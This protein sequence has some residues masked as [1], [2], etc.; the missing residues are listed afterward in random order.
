I[1][2]TRERVP[3]PGSAA[4][5]RVR[6]RPAAE[7][8]SEPYAAG[9][10]EPARL[11]PF[12]DGRRYH[13]T[14]LFH[15][16]SGFPTEDPAEVDALLRRLHAKVDLHR[17]ELPAV[18]ELELHDAEV[19]VFACGI[20]AR[21]ARAAVAQARAGGLR[22]GLLRPLTL[23][24]FPD[25]A[26]ARTA[27]QVNTIV[28]AEM[29]LGQLAREVARAAAGACRVDQLNRVDGAPIWPAQVLERL[30]AAVPA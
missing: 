5:A 29:N 12:G 26:V 30:R 15:D 25:E 17:D 14:G 11:V 21:A 27:R 4:L 2:H 19:A 1:G 10:D 24:P 18:E 20:A 13:V 28:A 6:P 22:A 3:A 23:R 9:Q 16:A 7:P 8:R